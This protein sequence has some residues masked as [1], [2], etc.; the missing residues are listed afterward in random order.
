MD[1]DDVTY[2]VSWEPLPDGNSRK[3]RD[4]QGPET[5]KEWRKLL[6][7]ARHTAQIRRKR[8]LDPIM[9]GLSGKK[10]RKKKRLLS[11]YKP[12]QYIVN[13]NA[14]LA[15]GA[16]LSCLDRWR[17]QSI[18]DLQGFPYWGTLTM[19]S[20]SGYVANLGYDPVTAYTVVAD[21]HS[22]RWVDIQTRAVFVE[23]TVY[24]ANTN[25]F[26]II[27]Y[28]IEF[29]PSSATVTTSQYHAARFY[30]HL[31]G[32]QTLAHVLVIFFMLYFLYRE[33]KQVYKQRWAYFKGF[34]NW[35]EVILIISEFL[36]IVLF[37]ARLYEVDRNIHQLRENPNDYVGFQYAANADALMTYVIGTLVFFYILRFLRLL[38]FN[39][40]FLVI[41]KTLSRISSPI[42][43]FC[44]PFISG[45]FA[46]GMLAFTMFGTELEDYS[47]FIRTMV[48][49][50]SIA[51]GDFDF[52]AIFM[53]NPTI[54]T[55]YFFSFIGLNVMVLM[56]MFIAII[57]DSYA[58]IQ[59]ETADIENELEIV[60][61]VTGGLT[62]F[63]SS[64]FHRGK[65]APEKKKGKKRK[66][67]TKKLPS[68][69]EFANQ[70][71]IRGK[72]LE[73]VVDIFEESMGQ[74]EIEEEKFLAVP[75]NK[76]QDLFFRLLCLMESILDDDDE[77]ELSDEEFSGE[78]FSNE[79]FSDGSI[80]QDPKEN[81][82][83]ELGAES[84]S[85]VSAPEECGDY[86]G[87]SSS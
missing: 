27:S 72:K 7:E 76:Q 58:E 1:E 33:G 35:I 85:D 82:G 49:Q 40:N 16:V 24:N 46:F 84:G 6:A 42:L 4:I 64:K 53:V 45:F 32:A 41:G 30:L 10:R 68:F 25:L 5:E 56:N 36:L 71:D 17:H 11:S 73:I 39:K 43:S 21:L 37:L 29:S 19:Y 78:E 31:N 81:S 9:G 66:R 52:E 70:L 23:F 87:D 14:L 44:L 51:L 2:D 69:E 50:F 15:D 63:V 3:R 28:F 67:K 80:N 83:D 61:Y 55:L 26:G 48:T 86:S 13:D 65:V 20:G 75:K 54:A 8:G 34:W 77:G 74:D 38:R 47:S 62:G 79:E 59:E 18:V 60:E 22:N 12:K 57:N